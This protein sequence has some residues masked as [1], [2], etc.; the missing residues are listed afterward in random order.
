MTTDPQTRTLQQ[1]INE[2]TVQLNAL[3]ADLQAITNRPE[4]QPEEPT[5]TQPRP[6]RHQ[7][8]Q[9]GIAIYIGDTVLFRPPGTRS[10][11]TQRIRGIIDSFTAQRVYIRRE[12]DHR[13]T[14]QRILRDPAHT[15]LVPTANA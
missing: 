2:L 6:Q 3:Q 8:D 14:P 4:A 9:Q 12:T 11:S 15:R 13:P 7:F 10:N 1:Q 5:F